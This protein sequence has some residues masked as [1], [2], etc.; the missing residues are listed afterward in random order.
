MCADFFAL[1]LRAL[2]YAGAGHDPVAAAV[3]CAPQKAA[4]TVVNGKFVV[5]AG[6]VVTVDMGPVVERHNQVAREMVSG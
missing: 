6:Q 5:K 3:F 4:Y 1:D 2:D